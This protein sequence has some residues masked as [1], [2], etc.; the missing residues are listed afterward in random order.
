MRTSFQV[1]SSLRS[2][3]LPSGP[4][5]AAQTRAGSE[6]KDAPLYTLILPIVPVILKIWL[7][8][9]VIGGFVIAGFLALFLCGRMKGTFKENCQLVNKLYYDGVVD[10]A[11]LVGFL[12]TLPMFNSVASL[13][14]PYFKAVLGPVVPR[15]ELVVCIAFA[16]LLGM[17]NGKS[18]ADLDRE[19]KG[20]CTGC[21]QI[22][23]A[24]DPYLFGSEEDIQAKWDD[25]VAAVNAAE[26]IK[27]GGHVTCPGENTEARR[28]QN[29]KE[30]VVVDE[31]IW[32]QIQSLAAGNMETRDISST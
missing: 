6:Q 31:Q 23:I 7:D 1:I 16:I 21:C 26:P 29:L 20:S 19:K 27:E 32:A 12:L 24:V 22:F 9:S 14:S 8:F 17:A 4:P 5:W 11:P 3:R 25:R 13:A 28:E 10:T 18:G 15:T 30:G 2:G